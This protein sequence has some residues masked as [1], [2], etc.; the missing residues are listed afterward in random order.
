M[1]CDHVANLG[2]MERLLDWEVRCLTTQYDCCYY[3]PWIQLRR[4]E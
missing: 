4:Q 1:L 2:Y 3:A